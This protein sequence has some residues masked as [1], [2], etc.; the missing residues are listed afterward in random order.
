MDLSAFIRRR[1]SPGLAQ[2]GIAPKVDLCLDV[3]ATD[4][5]PENS[6]GT[7]KNKIRLAGGSSKN[8]K[9]ISFFIGVN[10]TC[11]SNHVPG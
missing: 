1:P 7:G 10:G 3:T 2:N 5:E 8:E 11:G 6:S 4:C 9:L